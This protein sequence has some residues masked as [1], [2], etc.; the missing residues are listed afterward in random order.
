MF[1]FTKERNEKEPE[2][3]P[4]YEEATAV[5]GWQGQ[6]TGKAIETLKSEIMAHIGKL[7]GLVSGFEK[8]RFGTRAGF[9]IHY[10]IETPEGKH[11]PGYI[12]VAALPLKQHQYF[13][14]RNRTPEGVL[15]D[16]SLRMALYNVTVCLGS[17]W[18]LQRLSPGFAPLMPFMVG[19]G[20]MNL[21][22]MW[23]SGSVMKALMPP[24]EEGE[25][26]FKH[27]GEILEAETRDAN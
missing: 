7:G 13:D 10:V 15:L 16:R 1:D 19:Q 26:K 24:D 14:R 2:Q 11:V 23:S 20:G 12:D 4:Y 9:R 17:L 8:G 21:T 6:A 22:H 5:N 18:K 27:E 3:V 25:N